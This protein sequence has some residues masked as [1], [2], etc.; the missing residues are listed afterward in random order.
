MHGM[1]PNYSNGSWPASCY[2]AHS[3]SDKDI[4]K[5][6]LDDLNDR[7]IGLFSSV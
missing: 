4:S 2:H 6:V 5:D 3:Y 7:W 1:W